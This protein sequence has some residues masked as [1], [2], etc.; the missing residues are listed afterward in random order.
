LARGWRS[1]ADRDE[2]LNH[3]GLIEIA[4]ATDLLDAGSGSS[5]DF[6]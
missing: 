3:C 1:S 5:Y 6:F 2:A 4:Q